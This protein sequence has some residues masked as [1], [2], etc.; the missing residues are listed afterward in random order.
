MTTEKTEGQRIDS[1][2]EI[3]SRYGGTDEMHH[4][5]WVIDQV[6][7][8]LLGEEYGDWVK[9]MTTGV[10]ADYTWEEGIAP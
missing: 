10:N 2:M 6:A 8:A 9:G 7:R 1:A 3:I 5:R 4:A